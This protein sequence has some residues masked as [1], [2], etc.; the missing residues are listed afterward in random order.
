[1][2]V[3]LKL[4]SSKISLLHFSKTSHDAVIAIFLHS[5]DS[6]KISMSTTSIN[7]LP[8]LPSTHTHFTYSLTLTAQACELY[9]PKL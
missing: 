6:T 2:I 7:N 5:R 9:L 1:M 4:Y 3:H 8:T